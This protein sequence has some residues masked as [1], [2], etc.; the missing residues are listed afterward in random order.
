MRF[1]WFLPILACWNLL[2][3]TTQANQ[4]A[5]W[6]TIFTDD[7]EGAS[8]G[9]NWQMQI[10]EDPAASWNIVKDGSNSVLAGQGH[11]FLYLWAGSWGDYRFK[12]RV[13]LLQN[14][15]INLNYRNAGCTRYFVGF[16][17]GSVSLNRTLPCGTHTPL[18]SVSG[19]YQANQWYVV[20]IVGVGPNVRVYVDG[21][22]KIDYTDANPVLFGRAAYESL[23]AAPV[24]LD[25]VEISGP[26]AAAVLQKLTWSKVGGPIGGLGYDVRM[27]PDNPDAMFATD[28]FSGV[29]TSLD[30]GRTWSASNNGITTRTGPSGDAIPVFSLTNDPHNPNV[31]WAG[32][33]NAR[34]IFKSVDGGR[35]W[36]EMTNGIVEQIGISFRGF[37]VDPNDS[38]TV[39]AAAEISSFEW[40]G[41]SIPGFEFDLTKG[42]VYRT[43]DGGRNWTAIWRG[44]NLARY[45]WIDPRDSSVMYISTGI[46]DREAANSD[47][48]HGKPGGVGIV[49]T[50]DGG[51]I[52]QVL[53]QANGL[54]NLYVGSL[55]LHPQ[56][57]DIL[58][59]GTGMVDYSAGAGIY[60]STDRG[61]T[62]RRGVSAADHAPIEEVIT[63][64]EF[65]VSDPRVAYAC[66]SSSFYRSGDGGVTWSIRSGGPPQYYYGPHGIQT[67]FPIDLQVD[68]RDPNRVFINNYGGGNFLSEDGGATWQTA[69]KGYTGAQLHR[70]VLD[71]ADSGNL[72]VVGRSGPFRSPDGGQDWVGLLNGPA[73]LGGPYSVAL[74][75]GVP[76]TILA[77][78]EFYG[79]LFRSTDG[80]LTWKNVFQNSQVTGTSGARHGFKALAFAQANPQTV[81][82]GMCRD[83]NT[84]DAGNPPPSFGVFKST[85]GGITWK[86]SNDSIST[87]QNINVLLI[88]AHDPNTVYAGTVA[89][90]VLKSRDGGATWK[91]SNQGLKT[92]DVR[93]L[94]FDAANSAVL[95]AGLEKGGLYKS[96]DGG[97][98]WQMSGAGMDPQA[99][100]RDIVADP[101]NSGILYAADYVTGVYRS[102]DRGGL[103]IAVN[104]G[105]STRAVSSLAI[106]SDAST[107]YAATYG[108][109]VFRL[110]LLPASGVA[111]GLT[112]AA[113]FQAGGDLAAESI[114]SAFGTS[115]ADAPAAAG[116]GSLPTTIGDT[117]VS[118]MDASG[119]ERSAPLFF[120]SPGQINFLL[121]SGLAEG[122]AVVRVF[123]QGNVVARGSANIDVVAP[124]LFTANADGK[125]VPA[126]LA[127][128]VAA[129]GAQSP[130]NVYRCGTAQGS[131][132]PVPID[133]G[134]ATD[135]VV[136]ELFGTGI[137]GRSALPA[138]TA[139]IGGQ[140]ADVQ[141]AGPQGGFMGLDQVNIGVPRSLA[142]RG[143]VDVVLTVDGKTA[144]TVTVRVL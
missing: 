61:A 136:L 43:H 3:Q 64:V 20:E 4:P 59:A 88:D 56:N 144:N 121:P 40:A 106:A 42:V 98:T 45:V 105:L 52:W 6:Q 27:R 117:S 89:S 41:T 21:A 5:G 16:G 19:S 94:A 30:G 126:A 130:L 96:A 47:L 15:A 71:A 93:S 49:N 65:S 8:L 87:G 110:D 10:L 141:Y 48:V 39:Y 55:F 32:T 25:D 135:Q 38:N 122:S 112:S 97:A 23:G 143:A 133:L 81:F 125:G 51:Q 22:L 119:A 139:T 138:V 2:A 102:D 24:Y 107:L 74:N 100:V 57:P 62:W 90:G 140:A 111:L 118:V 75:P 137:R 95:Y 104:K 50:T 83:R 129:S 127:V 85:D 115:L 31:I 26:P 34:G 18:V 54:P 46:F 72:F 33:Q 79:N 86:A 69:S 108:E 92:L 67:G 113:A 1:H 103:W 134:V 14:G 99:S 70:V 12:T 7:F 80:G 142:G 114:A 68:P 9:S 109:G 123:H 84:V 131:C 35:S 66:G 82:A 101:T 120:V 73:T 63:S 29:N 128:R 116:P 58:L 36:A 91:Q 28:T 44:D 17:P 53:N 37:A 11:S 60:L 78:D 77:S 13:K 132:A 76:S 124:G